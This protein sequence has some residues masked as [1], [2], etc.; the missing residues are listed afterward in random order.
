MYATLCYVVMYTDDSEE[1]R[2]SQLLH[3]KRV[4]NAF[5]TF[6]IEN[7]L[8]EDNRREHVFSGS[9]A[10]ERYMEEVDIK[11]AN[12]VYNHESC[13]DECKRR[14]QKIK[15]VLLRQFHC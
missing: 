2:T 9:Q 14:G 15:L 3:R 8:T 1:V 10:Q 13:S 12:S 6:Q 5:W 11:R 7:E 4:A